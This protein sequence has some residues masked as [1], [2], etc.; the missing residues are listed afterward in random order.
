MVL[1]KDIYSPQRYIES[2]TEHCYILGNN[3][4]ILEEIQSLL[5]LNDF[6]DLWNYP[7]NEI[8]HIV[9]NRINVVL[10]DVS[11]IDD[12]SGNW[13]QEYRWFEVPES[14]IDNFKKS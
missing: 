7:L 3:T 10:V 1:S 12:E 6:E 8:G 4:S 13:V 2:L 5:C 9:E 14:C 11:D